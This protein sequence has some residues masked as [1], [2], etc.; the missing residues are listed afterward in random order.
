MQTV[1]GHD[2]RHQDCQSNLRVPG[3]GIQDDNAHE[4]VAS[5]EEKRVVLDCK[6]ALDALALEKRCVVLNDIK[7]LVVCAQ[8]A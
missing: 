2:Q 5:H 7:L 4:D 3:I 6:P 1:G 8:L